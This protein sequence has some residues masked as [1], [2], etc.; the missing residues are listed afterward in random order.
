MEQIQ[1][2]VFR[3]V[4]EQRISELWRYRRW[5]R[6]NRGADW[7][8]IRRDLETELRALVRLVRKARKIAAAV[9]DPMDVAKGYEDW[10]ESEL[11]GAW[12]R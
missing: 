1:D 7:P 11:A 12:G 6:A 10:T 9:P 4:V 2:H 5:W 3:I 8:I